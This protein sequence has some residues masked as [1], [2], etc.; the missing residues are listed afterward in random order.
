MC[1]IGFYFFRLGNDYGIFELSDRLED[2]HQRHGNSGR[3][4]RGNR[5]FGGCPALRRNFFFYHAKKLRFQINNRNRLAGW[6]GFSVLHLIFPTRYLFEI[7]AFS[8]VQT[9]LQDD[10][11]QNA[12]EKNEHS[13]TQIVSVSV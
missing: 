12:S 9:D 8:K 1:A 6:K 4:G 7:R 13:R 2:R 10:Q 3:S 5:I 11:D